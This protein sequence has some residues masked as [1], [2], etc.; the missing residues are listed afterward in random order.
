MASPVGHTLAGLAV[1][2]FSWKRVFRAPMR[3]QGV[4]FCVIMANLPDFDVLPGIFAGDINKFHHD[5]SHT[6][7]FA[8]AV[9]L[10]VYAVAGKNR[11]GWAFMAFVL[12]MSHFWLD[13][14]AV[15][16]SPPIGLRLLWPL[17][18]MAGD[19]F[20]WR[21]AFLPSVARG[22]SL[23]SLFNVHNVG[24]VAVETVVFLPPAIAAYLF[25]RKS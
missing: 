25:Y 20:K 22:G 23:P 24:V 5:H 18:D 3:W 9:T 19:G 4:L 16:T 11:R 6:F 8:F 1:G 14:I 13:F 12:I 2:F 10:V 21:Y 17:Q 7:L 15:D